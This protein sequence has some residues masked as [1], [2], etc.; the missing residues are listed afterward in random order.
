MAAIETILHLPKPPSVNKTR[1]IDYAGARVKQRW[2]EE[3]NAEILAAGGLRKFAK[4]PGRFELTIILDEKQ[5]RI[6]LDNGTKV[7]S[8][9]CKRLGLIVDD[10]KK[11]LRRVVLEWGQAER[12]CTVILRSI[13]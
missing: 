8:D 5:N 7:L 2:I 13:E 6:D 9:L 11:Y 3:C 1:R 10:R 12:G 4:M